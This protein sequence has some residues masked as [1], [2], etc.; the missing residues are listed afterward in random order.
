M[1]VVEEQKEEQEQEVEV[2]E[3]QKEE[4]EQEEEITDNPADDQDKPHSSVNPDVCPF[5]SSFTS[6]LKFSLKS[7]LLSWPP[8]PP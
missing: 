7:N 5:S 2:V 8:L 3:E 1:K 6:R 4:Q